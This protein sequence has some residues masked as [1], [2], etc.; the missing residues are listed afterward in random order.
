M[1]QIR[2]IIKIKFAVRFI[3]ASGG[4]GPLGEGSLYAAQLVGVGF[5]WFSG[6]GAAS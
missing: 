2:M 3:F 1:K 6:E 5:H 4:Q